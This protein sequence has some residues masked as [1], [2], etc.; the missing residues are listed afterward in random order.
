MNIFLI[1][2]NQLFETTIEHLKTYKYD[3]IWIFEEPHYFSSSIIKPNKIKIAYLRACMRYFY[4]ILKKDFDVEYY[5]FDKASLNP[6]YSYYSFELTDYKLVEKYKSQGIVVNELE[7]PMFILTRKDLDIYNKRKGVSHATLYELAKKKLGILEGVKNQ[8]VYNRSNPRTEVPYNSAL[9]FVNSSN[10]GYYEEAIRYANKSS[11]KNHVGNPTIETLGVYPISTKDALKHYED[12]LKRNLDKFGLYQDVIQDDNV[13]MYHS[14]ISPSLNNGLLI[15]MELIKIVRKYEGK[16]SINN[17]EGFVR[18]I[19]GWREYMRYLYLYKYE[20]LVNSN[21]FKNEKRLDKTWYNGTT[22][23][24][25]I[26]SEIAKAIKY[27]Y[28]HHI[29]RLMI[30]LNFMILS[31]IRP[32]DIYKWF[33]E[34]VSID[35]YDWVMVSNIYAMGY[36]SKIGMRRPYLS[37]SNYILKMSNYKRDGVWDKLWDEKFR[38]FVIEKK[39]GFYYRNIRK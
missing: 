36:F 29:T 26:D 38:N 8:D 13:F 5:E 28:S 17:Y 6:K 20:E 32:D 39:I 15:P 34:V 14:V 18:Q 23:L 2:P 37:T 21:S 9:D 3:K 16:T 27:G 22:G 30:F 31:E 19:I 7:T 33:M 25:V 1:L 11:F 24:M 35:A 10:R 4:D 12:F